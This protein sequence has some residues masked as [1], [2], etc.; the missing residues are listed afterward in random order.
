MRQPIQAILLEKIGLVFVIRKESRD[1][2]LYKSSRIQ[3]LQ[4]FSESDRR[5]ISDRLFSSS[6]S[7]KEDRTGSP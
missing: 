6:V 1:R 3:K 2:L 7:K 4:K 5:G